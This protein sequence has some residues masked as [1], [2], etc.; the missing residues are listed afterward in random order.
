MSKIIKQIS[1][2]SKIAAMILMVSSILVAVAI[3]LLLI[4]IVYNLVYNTNPNFIPGL[5]I[6]NSDIENILKPPSTNYIVTVLVLAVA[7][8]G[9]ILL[10]LL[11]L[12]SVFLS[13]SKNYTPF[14]S[15]HSKKMKAVS[16]LT[17]FLAVF[18]S[19]SDCLTHYFLYGSMVFK[20]NLLM[21]IASII[22]FSISQIFEYGCLLQTET[23]ELL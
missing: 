4:S 7:Q 16:L 14:S 11:L 5:F 21:I 18:G 15:A 17:I 8:L 6:S 23:D 3:V 22:I 19:V 9:I 1:K 2:S 10:I 12:H 20:I 13:I